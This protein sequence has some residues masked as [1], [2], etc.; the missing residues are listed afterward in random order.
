ML[1]Y[2]VTTP[3]ADLS[4]RRL[5]CGSCV[6][7]WNLSLLKMK[8]VCSFEILIYSTTP[9]GVTTQKTNKTIFIGYWS[10]IWMYSRAM[11]QAVSHRPL[12]AGS[13]EIC[14]TKWHWDRFSPSY[15]VSTFQ[16]VLPC[17]CII[18]EINN[19]PVG[20][21]SSETRCHPHRHEQRQYVTHFIYPGNI[22]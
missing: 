1:V 2:R 10:I 8:A 15:S 18:W 9:H 4:L 6:Y 13:C 3:P 7:I 16:L 21:W 19:R 5:L 14:G 11:A 22:F 20:G 12:I 17:P